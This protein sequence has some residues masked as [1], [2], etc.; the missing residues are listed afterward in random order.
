M[1]LIQFPNFLPLHSARSNSIPE[2]RAI[3][4]AQPIGERRWY[5]EEEV[6]EAEE[7]GEKRENAHAYIYVY[8]RNAR[9][10]Q[11][12]VYWPVFGDVLGCNTRSHPRSLRSAGAPS[13]RQPR[14][15][16]LYSPGKSGSRTFEEGPVCARR[17]RK[18][19]VQC[20]CVS[21]CVSA[22]ALARACPRGC[23]S[24]HEPCPGDQPGR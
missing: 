3:A 4:L 15:W 20:A 13:S 21:L 23:L 12:R 18:I 19:T 5:M 6:K 24:L 17:S 10:S 7:E 14:N 8:N 16:F 1:P 2:Q 9:A 22:P 11:S